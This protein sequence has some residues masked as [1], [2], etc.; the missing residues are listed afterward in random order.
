VG[1]MKS[2]AIRRLEGASDIATIWAHEP[3]VR[4]LVSKGFDVR[5]ACW[6]WG[7]VG[8]YAGDP[9]AHVTRKHGGPARQGGSGN[10]EVPGVPLAPEENRSREAAV[11]IAH[12][13]SR[14]W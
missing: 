7:L 11:H 2:L 1:L 4:H 3:Y 10:R 6:I 13:L 9:T 14:Y 12:G 8:A 5:T